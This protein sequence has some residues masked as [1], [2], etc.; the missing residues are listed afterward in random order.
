MRTNMIDTFCTSW[1]SLV[2]R[3][4]SEAAENAPISASEK[5]TTLENSALRKS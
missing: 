5:E 4:M 2:P 1:T 3:V